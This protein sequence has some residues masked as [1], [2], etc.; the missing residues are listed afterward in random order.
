M[1]SALQEAEEAE[2]DDK[3]KPRDAKG[4]VILTEEEKRVKAEKEAKKSAEKAAERKERVEKLV[5][6]LVRKISIFTESA[7]G[8]ND[9]QV[10]QS[11]R[12]I[13]QLEAEYVHSPILSSYP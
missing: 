7:T 3:D 8:V 5:E 1:K 11:W 13:C 6:N 12:T 10:T 4:K 2:E 9:A